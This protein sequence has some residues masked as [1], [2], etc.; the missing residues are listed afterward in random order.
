VIREFPARS[1]TRGIALYRPLTPPL[2][3]ELLHE[4]SDDSEPENT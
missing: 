4:T 1:D 3:R 2:L